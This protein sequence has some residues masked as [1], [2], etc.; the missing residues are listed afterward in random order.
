M[1]LS[2]RSRYG[3]R[4]ILDLSTC[5]P[6]G[7]ITLRD[8]CNRQEIPLI[9]L[10]NVLTPLRASGLV[11]T[12]QGNLGGYVLGKNPSEITV[13]SILRLLEK[14]ITLVA[15]VEDPAVC[16]QSPKCAARIIWMRLYEAITNV[17]DEITLA[18][19]IEIQKDLTS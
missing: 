16:H 10:E 3:L 12:V 14:N 4:A 15:C 7:P 2:T 13:G 17:I 6:E 9:Y 8:I 5:N 18:D 19:M 11:K 1:K